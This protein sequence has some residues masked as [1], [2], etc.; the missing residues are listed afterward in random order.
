MQANDDD[1]DE[2]CS[3]DVHAEVRLEPADDEVDER[4]QLC[5]SGDRETTCERQP[6]T[7]DTQML[8]F[9]PFCSLP[10]RVQTLAS[11]AASCLSLRL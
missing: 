7:P 4:R 11:H 6:A 5:A 2:P 9:C 10:S 3:S 8:K 1:D